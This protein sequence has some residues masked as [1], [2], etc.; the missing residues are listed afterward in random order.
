MQ[1]IEKMYFHSTDVV[2]SSL[3]PPRRW[4]DAG[5][6]VKMLR[7]IPLLENRK[8]VGIPLPENRKVT[9]CQFHVFLIGMKF[10]SKLLEVLFMQSVSS[11]D[12][13]L[14]KS[15]S[16]KDTQSKHKNKTVSRAFEN[17]KTFNSFRFPDMTIQ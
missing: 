13:H 12:P 2:L 15:I 9:K 16:K 10:I 7:G 5:V 4:S 17:F 8:S 11:A 3:C 6:G 14:H 1:L